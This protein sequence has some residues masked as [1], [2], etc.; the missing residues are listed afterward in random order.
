[1][2]RTL[3]SAASPW[4][5]SMFTLPILTCPSYSSANSSRIGPI[6]LHGPHHSA[7]KS[8]STGVEAFSTSA[9]K[10]S[11]VKVTI[12]GAAIIKWELN[13]TQVGCTAKSGPAAPAL[14]KSNQSRPC[15]QV[16]Q[17]LPK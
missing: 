3:Y 1:M 6:I 5:W 17:K 2:A 12:L 14:L 15:S 9:A 13:K 4:C 10:F 11:C 16:R 8:T 7:Q